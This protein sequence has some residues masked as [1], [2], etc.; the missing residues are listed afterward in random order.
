MARTLQDKNRME[1]N[2]KARKKY[3]KENFKYQSVMFKIEE[4]EAIND[5][6]EQNNIPKNTFFREVCM[7]AIGKSID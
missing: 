4:I 1:Y 3:D 2:K 6:C 5:Y 7:A